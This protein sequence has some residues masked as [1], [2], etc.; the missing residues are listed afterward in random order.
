MLWDKDKIKTVLAHREPFLFIDEVVE[1]NGTESVVAVKNIK[2]D[3]A[4]FEGHFPGSPVMPGVLIIEAMAQA[5]IVL[6]SVAKPD[7]AGKNPKYYLGK[8][9]SEFFLPVYPGQKLFIEAMKVKFLD[10]AGIT[11]VVTR[12]DGKIVAKAN[13]VFSVKDDE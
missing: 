10:Y 9:R 2:N 13:I 8:T 7:V 4:Y 5:S 6:Y 12:V 11:D 1:I 3:E